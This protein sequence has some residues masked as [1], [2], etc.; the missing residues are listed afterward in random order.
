MSRKNHGNREVLVANR[1]AKR[2]KTSASQP[3]LASGSLTPLE[4]R[5]VTPA[6]QLAYSEQFDK[7]KDYAKANRLSLDS[8]Y[9]LDLALTVYINHLYHAGEGISSARNVLFGTIFLLSKPKGPNTFPRA[10]RTL[11]GFGKGDPPLSEDPLPLE[12]MALLAE[13]LMN[14]SQLDA[15]LAGM[16]L[17]TGF[18]LF[19]RPTETLS[20]LREDILGPVGQLRTT[21]V[22]VAQTPTAEE[23]L[24]ARERNLPLRDTRPAKAGEV[25]DT[26]MA[27]L[28]GMKLEFLQEALV[29]LS[30]NTHPK[31]PVFHPLNLPRY[32]T[33]VRDA[34]RKCSLEVLKAS[35]HSVR[36]GGASTAAYHGLLDIKGIMRR[37]RWKAHNSVR[38]YEKHG[39][40]QRQ[41]SKLTPKQL[42]RAGRI[43]E[44]IRQRRGASSSSSSAP[45]LSTHLSSLGN[46]F[47][48][49][50]HHMKMGRTFDTKDV[51]Y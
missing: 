32:E 26:V 41:L 35:P 25:D 13:E 17:V 28:P 22:M 39:R 33:L 42:Q 1:A 19:L 29:V 47:F 46:L 49:C 30:D 24:E 4:Q 48:R 20:L 38:R 18:D 34:A 37:G 23:Q 8:D 50:A 21:A 2:A 7:F 3:Q 36:H 9:N 43:L 45:P 16:A 40:L 15:K 31:Y 44:P 12:G 11:R 5:S 14:R 27:G 6:T 51:E 10:R